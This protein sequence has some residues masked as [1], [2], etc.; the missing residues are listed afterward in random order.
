[1]S[2]DTSEDGDELK[3]IDRQKSLI[4]TWGITTETFEPP[5][6]SDDNPFRQLPSGIHFEGYNHT[7]SCPQCDSR[8]SD[9]GVLSD[10][11]GGIAGGYS[12]VYLCQSCLSIWLKSFGWSEQRDYPEN[13]IYHKSNR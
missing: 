1:M 11:T 4:D 10:Y 13:H 8:G 2:V 12:T 5:H 9:K 7:E 3:G 6:S